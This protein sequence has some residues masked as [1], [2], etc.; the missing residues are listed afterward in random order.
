MNITF[1]E[2]DHKVFH[3]R[4]SDSCV[5]EDE[6]SARLY[7]ERMNAYY[8]EMNKLSDLPSSLNRKDYEAA[9]ARLGVEIS[10]DEDIR[11]KKYS[12]ENGNFNPYSGGYYME[13]YTPTF[14]LRMGL[15]G[16]RLSAISKENPLNPK[17]KIHDYP[18][19]RTLDCGHTVY[20]KVMVMHASMG[21]CCP[22]CYDKFSD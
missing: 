4:T 7:C 22:D 20:D 18:D 9:A 16:R 17:N 15:E 14:C 12:L 19:G 1:S 6:E 11:S 13:A 21:S 5:F 2:Y 3:F 10:S 8:D